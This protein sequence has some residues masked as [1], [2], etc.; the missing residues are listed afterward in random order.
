MGGFSF[1]ENMVIFLAVK[2]TI[3]LLLD[4][5]NRVGLPTSTTI[6]IVIGLLGGS[7]GVSRMKGNPG[8]YQ[9]NRKSSIPSQILN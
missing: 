1:S 7:V 9:V 2:L 5:F 3:I 8:E 6:S 4:F